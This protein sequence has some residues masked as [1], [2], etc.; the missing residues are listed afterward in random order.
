MTW[1]AILDAGPGAS[2]S[3]P[4]DLAQCRSL[5][6]S[7]RMTGAT[8]VARPGAGSWV[9]ASSEAGLSSLFAG[10]SAAPPTMP[11]PV[12]APGFTVVPFEV[13]RAISAAI[14]VTKARWTTLLV[15]GLVYVGVSLVGSAPQLIAMPFARSAPAIYIGA[16]MLGLALS[17]CVGL[18]AI[19]GVIVASAEAVEGRTELDPVFSGFK[20]FG[21]TLG[22]GLL[23]VLAI[24]A[25]AI[26]GGVGLAVMLALAPA[27]GGFPSAVL[28][29][30][31]IVIYVAGFLG[32]F[33]V[34]SRLLWTSAIA[35]DAS[36]G[37]VGAVDAFKASWRSTSKCWPRIAGAIFVTSLLAGASVLLLCVGYLLVG[38]PLFCG[39]L[40]IVHASVIRPALRT[41]SAG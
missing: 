31:G 3:G 10:A 15:I 1:Y 26:V 38:M 14:G 25:P 40:G 8:L 4:F 32:A 12:A 34:M 28:G 24:G 5:V 21:A 9:P 37:S 36:L 13:G 30:L 19:A 39:M 33:F 35:C 29:L 41:A 6:A 27:V 22:A 7:G 16:G 23:A 2:P 18:P 11:Q 20:R 17:V